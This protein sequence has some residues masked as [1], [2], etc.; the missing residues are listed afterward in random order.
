VGVNRAAEHEEAS[1]QVLRSAD[2]RRHDPTDLDSHIEGRYGAERGDERFES[3]PGVCGFLIR[4]RFSRVYN[5]GRARG[6]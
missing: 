4:D 3:C 5:T 1:G 2:E 6:R